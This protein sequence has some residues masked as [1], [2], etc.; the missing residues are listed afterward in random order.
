MRCFWLQ[1]DVDVN[2]LSGTG[3]VAEIVEFEDGTVVM[4]WMTSVASTTVMHAD[5]ESVRKLHLHE[6]KSR[7]VPVPLEL[8][9]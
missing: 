1:R 6:G 8:L 4:R 2:G 9:R 5:M 3:R 7:I